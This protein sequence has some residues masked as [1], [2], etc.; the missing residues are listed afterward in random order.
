MVVL[1]VKD[2]F[3]LFG[4]GRVDE[5]FDLFYEGVY[6]FFIFYCSY[7][8]LWDGSFFLFRDGEIEVWIRIRRRVGVLGI[9]F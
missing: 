9:L 8:Y 2:G 1:K 4:G 6:L 3:R 7:G 5:G